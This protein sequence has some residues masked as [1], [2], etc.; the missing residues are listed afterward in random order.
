[1]S[2][3]DY[4]EV[5]GVSRDADKKAIKKRIVR[6]LTSTTRIKIQTTKKRWKS[7]KKLLKPMRFYQQKRS[8][9]PMIDLVMK[10]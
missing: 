7:S 3:R 10:V 6:L 4:Y 2:K 9:R 1:M 8:V 5:L